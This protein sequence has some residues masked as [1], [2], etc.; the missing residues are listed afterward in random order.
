MALTG[1]NGVDLQACR[2]H[3][4]RRKEGGVCAGENSAGQDYRA[5]GD[6]IELPPCPDPK[7]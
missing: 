3:P 4:G 5:E 6:G 2:T 1:V 7:L